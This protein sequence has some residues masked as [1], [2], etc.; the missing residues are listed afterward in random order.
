MI[1]R[2]YMQTITA[3]SASL[4]LRAEARLV[5]PV[6]LRA[7]VHDLAVGVFSRLPPVAPLWSDRLGISA[8]CSRG[9]ARGRRD[10][11]CSERGPVR[12]KVA[13]AR[14]Q[15]GG[16]NSIFGPSDGGGSSV[17]FFRYRLISTLRFASLYFGFISISLWQT[18]WLDIRCSVEKPA[19]T[20]RIS[21]RYAL[22]LLPNC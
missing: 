22:A 10:L 8:T 2:H 18:D 3:S 9:R 1:N 7:L 13:A 12:P 21:V 6:P 11:P 20:G 14:R 17:S 4:P 16:K 19:H 5:A 15:A